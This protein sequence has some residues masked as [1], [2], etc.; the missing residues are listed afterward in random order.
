MG[1]CSGTNIFDAVTEALLEEKDNKP[2]DVKKVL[3]VLTYVLEDNDWDCQSDSDYYEHP[4]VQEIMKK[5]HPKWFEDE[6][7]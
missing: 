3:T 5:R 6:G 7:E 1:W 2:V 4:I